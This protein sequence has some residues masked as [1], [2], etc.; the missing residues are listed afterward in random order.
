MAKK[1]PWMAVVLNVVLTGSGYLYLGKRKLF[2]ILVLLSSIVG[3]VGAYNI[4]FE[5]LSSPE[6]ILL[7]VSGILYWAAFGFDAYKEAVA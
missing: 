5:N 3:Y 4:H 6:L 2:G 1:N 7:L